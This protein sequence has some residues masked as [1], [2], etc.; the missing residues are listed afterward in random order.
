MDPTSHGRTHSTQAQNGDIASH[1]S[2]TLLK[3]AEL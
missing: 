1:C 2:V 3:S